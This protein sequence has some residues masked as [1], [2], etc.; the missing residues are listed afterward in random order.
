MTDWLIHKREWRWKGQKDTN[1]ERIREE[2]KKGGKD[3]RDSWKQM[4]RIL[5][6]ILLWGSDRKWVLLCC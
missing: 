2:G 5:S 1:K 3:E 4:K 6:V